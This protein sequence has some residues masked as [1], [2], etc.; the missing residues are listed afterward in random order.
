MEIKKIFSGDNRKV[1]APSLENAARFGCA[2]S[3]RRASLM[4]SIIILN[5]FFHGFLH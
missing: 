2:L 1:K 4:C 5:L 3:R